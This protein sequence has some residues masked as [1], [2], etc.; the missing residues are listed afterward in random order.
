MK[1]EQCSNTYEKVSEALRGLN[2]HRYAWRA[3]DSER[4]VVSYENYQSDGL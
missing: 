4:S 2:E 1:V 3:D